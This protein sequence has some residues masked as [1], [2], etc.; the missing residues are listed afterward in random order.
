MS[1]QVFFFKNI[2][3][4][5]QKTTFSEKVLEF[6]K[7]YFFIYFFL[8]KKKGNIVDFALFLGHYLNVI[9]YVI[10]KAQIFLASYPFH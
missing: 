8:K 5:V 10:S 9:K 3:S 7:I 6:R 2:H 4:R 1:T